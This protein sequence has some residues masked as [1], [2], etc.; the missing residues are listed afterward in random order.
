VT[1]RETPRP[2]IAKQTR[3]VRV[4][5][6][7]CDQARAREGAAIRAGRR[8]QKARA[9]HVRKRPP[10]F[11]LDSV[12]AEIAVA[13]ILGLEWVELGRPD[14]E[15]DLEGGIQVRQSRRPTGRLIVHDYDPDDFLCVL[16]TGT[17]PVYDVRGWLPAD[18]AK[19]VGRWTDPQPGR[20]AYFVDQHKLRPLGELY[21]LIARGC[22]V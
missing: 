17:F 12:G 15:G 7:E 10:G 9:E 16:V 2:V 8:N 22:A 11:E 4:R 6:G 21:H 18:V 13:N 20:F 19:Q 3:R 5:L 14:A 1:V